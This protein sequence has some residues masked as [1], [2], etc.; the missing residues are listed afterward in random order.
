M[1]FADEEE[2]N[3]KIRPAKDSERLA[4]ESLPVVA[5]DLERGPARLSAGLLGLRGQ[6]S[7]LRIF[8]LE[9]GVWLRRCLHCGRVSADDLST[10]GSAVQAT[11]K[12]QLQLTT[13]TGTGIGAA[14]ISP[15]I[16]KGKNLGRKIAIT[17]VNLATEELYSDPNG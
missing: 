13:R 8:L 1:S 14:S 5:K 2:L 10:Y 12:G 15:E 7:V 16:C 17:T 4:V 9:S 6:V 11:K 3:R